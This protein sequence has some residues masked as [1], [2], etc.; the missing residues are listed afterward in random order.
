MSDF[1]YLALMWVAIISGLYYYNKYK[2]NKRL[3][4]YSIYEDD[5]YYYEDIIDMPRKIY[6]VIERDDEIDTSILA[7]FVFNYDEL[8]K[9]S[10][11]RK[12]AS[13]DKKSQNI[14]K[15]AE[16]EADEK[17]ISKITTHEYVP[18]DE[19]FDDFVNES[20]LKDN[21][22]VSVDEISDNKI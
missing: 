15:E 14:A 5:D 10:Y 17:Y 12:E 18:D 13:D 8:I 11:V 22:N 21:E 6:I 19:D 1:F 16:K 7:D 3:E 20:N 4:E 2:K 9:G